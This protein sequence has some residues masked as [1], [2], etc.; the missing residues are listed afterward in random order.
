MTPMP[1]LTVI[2]PVFNNW[3]LTHDCLRSLAE[4]SPPEIGMRVIVADNGS[5]DATAAQCPVLGRGLFGDR[6]THLRFEQNR[7][8]GPA[9]NAAA[10]LAGT[11]LLFFL[12]NDTLL[13][14]GWL[15]P[16]FR[17]LDTEPGILGVGPL[18]TYANGL[19]QHLGISF[20]PAGSRVAHL[21]A[22]LPASHPLAQK[23]RRF[24]ALT[25]AALL[26]SRSAFLAAGGF[27]EEYVNG[28]EDVDLCLRLCRD[29]GRMSVEPRSRV[30]HLE[31]QSR[32]RNVSEGNNSLLLRS[33]WD[34]APLADL[35]AF[36]RD[37]GYLLRVDANGQIIFVPRPEPRL[38]LLNEL[39]SRPGADVAFFRAVQDKE[40]FWD[41]GY[42]LM[43]SL[44]ESAGLREEA[45]RV[46]G[47]RSLFVPS[48]AAYESLFQAWKNTPA[49]QGNPV[50]LSMAQEAYNRERAF[51]LDKERY[52][53]RM[54]FCRDC[55]LGQGDEELAAAY[56][57][58][59]RQAAQLRE[60]WKK[61]L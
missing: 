50:D 9:C 38:E 32:G 54:A 5:S 43:A 26:L 35:A 52:D 51:I 41:E 37:D 48:V 22:L 20:W 30:I 33:R 61:E 39:R 12:N 16:L 27:F 53:S 58:A 17:L 19:V 10:R 56:E 59:S 34:L 55:V 49:I 8:F 60:R 44:L 57:E 14:P 11:D 13:T 29:G 36:A 4:H 28:F 21:Y 24:R 6:F 25:A 23:R 46:L 2:I 15:P 1:A 45:L 42:T 40:P 31:G 3:Q 47:R 7:N 18:L